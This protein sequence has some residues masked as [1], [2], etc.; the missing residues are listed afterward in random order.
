MG[1]IC[2]RYFDERP[3]A[4]NCLADDPL[5]PED[6]EV[7]L[8]SN[9][10]SIARLREFCGDTLDFYGEEPG[11][12]YA[13]CCAD[14][15]INELSGQIL[16]AKDIISRC[17]ACWRNFRQVFCELACSPYQKHFERAA[18]FEKTPPDPE[19]GEI[20]RPRMV[21]ELEL[22]V[23]ER[24]ISSTYDSCKDIVMG[25]ANSPAMDF[26]CGPHSSLR[27]SPENWFGYMGDYKN[28]YAPFHI[29]FKT[30][31]DDPVDANITAFD[32]ITYHCNE[33]WVRIF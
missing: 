7:K 24:Y 30:K 5:H 26:L 15:Q 2:H 27:C 8:L 10:T 1:P 9:A 22:Y 18:L 17:P 29:Y 16:M 3:K 13:L 19:T 12:G 23:T 25:S 11:G 33:T 6:K 28:T 4:L 21:R 31:S 20:L 32:G 14:D